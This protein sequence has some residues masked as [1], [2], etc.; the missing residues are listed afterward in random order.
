MFPLKSR[1]E[2]DYLN[3]G[4]ESFAIKKVYYLSYDGL[5]KTLVCLAPEDEDVS[6]VPNHLMIKVFIFIEW[7]DKDIQ[8]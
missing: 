2:C 8:D 7:D 5:I 3:E 6:V 1:L 4:G